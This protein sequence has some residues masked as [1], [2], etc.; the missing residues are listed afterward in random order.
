MHRFHYV[1]A[2]PTGVH[3]EA[4][5]VVILRRHPL[6]V[7]DLEIHFHLLRGSL[8]VPAASSR[9]VLEVPFFIVINFL[10]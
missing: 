10:S 4:E 3:A 9:K 2:S 6:G 5:E 1:P 7:L 8:L